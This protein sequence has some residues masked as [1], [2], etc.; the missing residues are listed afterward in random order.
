MSGAERAE[1]VPDRTNA[2][3]GVLNDKKRAQWPSSGVPPVDHVVRL[4]HHSADEPATLRTETKSNPNESCSVDITVAHP[5]H[6][7]GSQR[8]SIR[9][10]QPQVMA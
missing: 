10:F 1:P 5:T 3:T 2:N 6:V 8:K 9:Y 7:E 4:I